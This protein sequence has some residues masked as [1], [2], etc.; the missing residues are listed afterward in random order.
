MKHD[1]E[2]SRGAT[3]EAEAEAAAS[4]PPA[5]A[6]NVIYFLADDLRPEL[7]GPYGQDVVSAPSLELLMS[8]GTTFTRAH[9]NVAV[10]SPS[11]MSFLTGK[12][13]HTTLAWNFVNHFRQANCAEVL[14]FFSFFFFR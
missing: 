5:G 2:S 1:P 6:K 12:L 10:C 14:L 3:E 4:A 7:P 11:R 8:R 9:C 13:P